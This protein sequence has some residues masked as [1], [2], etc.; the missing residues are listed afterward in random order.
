MSSLSFIIDYLSNL[1]AV[2]S[3]YIGL[4]QLRFFPFTNQ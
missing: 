4:A 2:I 3:Y 1:N